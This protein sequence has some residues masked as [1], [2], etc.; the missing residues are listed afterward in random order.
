MASESSIA[1]VSSG[2]LL[3]NDPTLPWTPDDFPTLPSTALAVTFRG[4]I[5][6]GTVS[7]LT[8]T[9]QIQYAPFEPES[10]RP[11][12]TKTLQI[13]QGGQ[14]ILQEPTVQFLSTTSQAFQQ[15]VSSFTQST[16][17]GAGIQDVTM[18]NPDTL[19]NA[20]GKL[21][22]WI[23]NAFL[24]QPPGVQPVASETN[25]FYGGVQW[26]NF[27]TYSILDKFVPYV[28]SILFIVGDPTTANYLTFEINDPT[29]FPY[30]TYTDGISPQFTPLVR[31]RIFT[32]CFVTTADA[33]YTK[34]VM[35]T[36]CVKIITEMGD[37]TLPTIGKVFAIDQT[38][39]ETTYTTVSL[40]LPNLP[41]SYPNGTE[42]PIKIVYLNKTSSPV[43]MTCAS[44][45]QATTGDPGPITSVT[46]LYTTP[47]SIV[48]QVVAPTYSDTTGL[49]TTPFFSTYQVQYTLQQMNSVVSGAPGIGFRYGI[50]DPT[51][52]P[53][54]E[55][56]YSNATYTQSIPFVT[57]NDV[58]KVTGTSEYPLVPGAQWS[59]S[60]SATNCVGNIGPDTALPILSTLFPTV[61]APRM[62]DIPLQNTSPGE[63]RFAGTLATPLYN[64]G[65]T[66]STIVPNDVF[67]FS[68][69]SFLNYQLSTSVQWNDATYPG[70]RN[71]LT[72]NLYHTDESGN[73]TNPATLAVA[74]TSDDFPLNTP[75]YAGTLD[76]NITATLTDSQVQPTYT[77]FFYN[78]G[79]TGQQYV[80]NYST[81]TQTIQVTLE[82]NQI[83]STLG[84]S[85]PQILSTSA[86]IFSTEPV[87]SYST[88]QVLVQHCTSTTQIS[89]IYTPSLTSQ[90]V[91]DV[92]TVNLGN[93]YLPSTFATGV[94]SSNGVPLGPLA[95]YTSNVH[96]FDGASEVTTLPFPADTVLTLS[97]L[98]TGFFSTIY[99]DPND[100]QEVLLNA[101][102]DPEHPQDQVSTFVSTLTNHVF[103]DTVSLVTISTFSNTLHSNGLRVVSLLPRLEAP[104]TVN[105]MNDGVDNAGNFGTG[106]NVAISSF[107]S[108]DSTNTLN[109]ST[110]LVY[111]H[112]SSIS[113]IYTDPYAR[114]LLYTN[115]HYI[116][117]AGFNFTQFSGDI[118]NVP[119]A[120]YPDFTYDLIYDQNGGYR[121]ATFLYELSTF[122]TP[123]PI[124]YLNILI[125]NPSF[126]STIQSDRTLNSCF[127]DAPVD[128]TYLTNMKV[129]LHAKV[130]GTFDAGT[131]MP[132]ETEWV[133]GFK[134]LDDTIYDDAQFDI[135]GAIEAT[136][137]NS[138][139]CYTVQFERRFY[140]KFTAFVRIG[141][142]QDGSVYSG[143]PLTFDAIQVSYGDSGISGILC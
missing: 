121:Y 131:S 119:N 141:I 87:K 82:N 48:V 105:N 67:F 27:P 41:N 32:N 109:V 81:A 80:T 16:I 126:I 62:S 86:Y 78:V 124:Q 136:L 101:T 8:L 120:V 58:I 135:G 79:I 7:T 60:I 2:S 122:A 128:P 98:T 24:L 102:V 88:L 113:T 26:L 52:I 9:N 142:S 21:D 97:S 70:D 13:N 92:E 143:D 34:T 55:A 138:D 127:P 59:T 25:V 54:D 115:G 42:V 6:T 1:Q 114:E 66:L 39:G 104:G 69:P 53:G 12:L 17:G 50:S 89:G 117:A 44:T 139:I 134:E 51:Q 71:T 18:A 140:T 137:I 74:S 28:N 14:V 110:S 46:P 85:T 37:A 93:Y 63:T 75:L 61:T 84:G 95:K 90:F 56:A 20:L 96:I 47:S 22:A 31:L 15:P 33:L 112:T 30:K 35:Q 5:A 40:Y 111:Q 125:K 130:L 129:R 3:F 11:S 64:D 38:D 108:I 103:I 100:P 65:W 91:F 45:V 76:A 72:L 118:I 23:T 133:N 4:T 19:T 36:K 29:L 106:L 10:I 107:A 123:T 43:T 94:L 83:P 116:H 77:Q 73:Q 57:C 68:T 99:Q 49:V 132:V